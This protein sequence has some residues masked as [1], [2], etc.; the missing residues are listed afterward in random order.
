MF[1]A[2]VG[3]YSRTVHVERSG[4]NEKMTRLR[5]FN[6]RF[7]KDLLMSTCIAVTFV[8]Y[9]KTNVASF[10]RLGSQHG[11]AFIRITV[12]PFARIYANTFH[13]HL[14]TGICTL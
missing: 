12:K 11:V 7:L 6:K 2:A 9:S 5:H 3:Q 1:P 8:I 4:Q 10:P 14:N 13:K